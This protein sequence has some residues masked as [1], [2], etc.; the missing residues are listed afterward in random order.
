M[1]VHCIRGV[2]WLAFSLFFSFLFVF[3]YTRYLYT[4]KWLL[5]R[6][7]VSCL[8]VNN[9]LGSNPIALPGETT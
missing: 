8:I 1:V 9:F 4:S 7:Y 5:L 2:E 6:L 3:L